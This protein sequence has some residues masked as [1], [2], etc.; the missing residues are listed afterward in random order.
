[1]KDLK[2]FEAIYEEQVALVQ[3]LKA[4]CRE[5]EDKKGDYE[6]LVK[7]YD[8]GQWLSDFETAK[9]TGKDESLAILSEDAI[10][11][12]ISEYF[13]VSIDLLELATSLIKPVEETP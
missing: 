7:Y 12:L 3:R 1:M 10:F 2:R 9:Q 11:H 5:V 6:A 4:L 13:N 8:D